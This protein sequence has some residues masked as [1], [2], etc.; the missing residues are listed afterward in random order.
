[1]EE[2]VFTIR[3]N[4]RG[5]YPGSLSYPGRQPGAVGVGV[6]DYSWQV[7]FGVERGP[8]GGSRWWFFIS[9]SLYLIIIIHL[10]YSPVLNL[11]LFS[12]MDQCFFIFHI[13]DIVYIFMYTRHNTHSG[14]CLFA[15]GNST[16]SWSINNSSKQAF[17]ELE[18]EIAICG[19]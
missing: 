11:V 3:L 13:Y 6:P 1:M 10:K 18:P 19:C 14:V 9:S 2:G 7:R 17:R 8:A 4:I 12:E 5:F 15:F 16:R